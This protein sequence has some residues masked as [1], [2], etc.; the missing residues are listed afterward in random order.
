MEFFRLSL[1]FDTKYKIAFEIINICSIC[2]VKNASTSP[3]KSHEI[4][5]FYYKKSYF[6]GQWLL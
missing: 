6:L 4:Y 3:R 2:F 1:H 5:A